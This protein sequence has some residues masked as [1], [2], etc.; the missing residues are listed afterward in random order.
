MAVKCEKDINEAAQKD[1]EIDFEDDES[2]QKTL[3]VMRNWFYNNYTDPVNETPYASAEGGYVWIYGGPYDAYEKISEQ[4]ED[5]YD[6][7]IIRHLADELECECIEWTRLSDEN[8]FDNELFEAIESNVDPYLTL[9]VSIDIAKKLL[10]Q[11]VEQ[12][13]KAKYYGLIFVNGI[14]IMETFLLDYF[15]QIIMNYEIIKTKFIC[16]TKE[17][18]AKKINFSEILSEYEKIDK[19]IRNYLTGLTWHNLPKVNALY[20]DTFDIDLS[21]HIEPIVQAVK[22]RHDIV[23]RNGKNKNGEETRIEIEMVKTLIEKVE[24]LA[25]DINEQSQRKIINNFA[26]R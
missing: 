24:I 20:R 17:F 19:T 16:T 1:E 12:E 8:Y 6:E 21:K 3:K 11:P 22:I 13:L 25:E 23:H 4:F 14:A 10:R 7:R 15:L 5:I 26:I 9:R 2:V 18:K